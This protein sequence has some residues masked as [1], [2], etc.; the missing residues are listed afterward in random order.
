[1]L[2]SQLT[3]TSIN[4]NV[5]GLSDL[6]SKPVGIF[7]PDVTEFKQFNL[8]SM[9]PLPWNN[10]EVRVHGPHAK[11]YAACRWMQHLF[12]PSLCVYVCFSG[13]SLSVCFMGRAQAVHCCGNMH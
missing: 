10:A 4:L 8:Q 6:I 5:R 9:V 7:E 12:V 3:V 2:S 1:M 11:W 13:Y